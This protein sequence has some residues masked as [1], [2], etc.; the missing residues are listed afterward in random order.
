MTA[1]DELLGLVFGVA[2]ARDINEA[3]PVFRNFDWKGRVC[4]RACPESRWIAVRVQDARELIRGW[5][6]VLFGLSGCSDEATIRYKATA[7][8]A[9]GDKVYSGS[10][11][12]QVTFTD[13]PHSLIGFGMAVSEK[14][15]AIAIDVGAGRNAVYLLLNDRESGKEFPFIV[16][17][18]FDVQSA[19]DPQWIDNL[20]NIPLGKKCSLNQSGFDRIKPSIMPLVVAFRDEEVP[21]SIFEVT[22]RSYRDAF[23]V[24]ARFLALTLERVDGSTPLSEGIDGRLP[25]LNQIP[26]DAHRRVLD[27]L[28]DGS[29]LTR[30]QAT[31]ANTVADYYFRE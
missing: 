15:E 3:C 4:R 16:L 23:G 30:Q 28:P 6:S 18:C 26:F 11:V 5:I 10:V 12:R 22:P 2:S 31:L 8:V 24:E 1:S 19:T 27:P 25:W 21:K 17:K 20:R 7:N 29:R 14:G 13:T 9:V